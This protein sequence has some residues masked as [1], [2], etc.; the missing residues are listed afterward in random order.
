MN[1]QN[2][3]N[4]DDKTIREKDETGK[5][6]E[7]EDVYIDNFITQLKECKI[8]WKKYDKELTGKM[9]YE[10]ANK[11]IK[12]ASTLLIDPLFSTVILHQVFQQEFGKEVTLP[13][14]TLFDAKKEQAKSHFYELIWSTVEQQQKCTLQ[15]TLTLTWSTFVDVVYKLLGT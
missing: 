9:E 14:N 6:E 4:N 11:Y 3:S 2:E 5:K 7:E 13:P 12:E 10:Q 1:D 8:L 15:S